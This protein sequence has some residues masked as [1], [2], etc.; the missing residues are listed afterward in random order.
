MFVESRD[1]SRQFFIQTWQKMTAKQ[2]LEPLEA[3]IAQI[4][5]EHPEY[6]AVLSAP[7]QT[8]DDE[9]LSEDG[10]SNPFLHMGLHV[11][12]QEQLQSDRPP[13]IVALYEKLLQRWNHD[14][15][16]TEHKMMECLA[17]ALWQA[18]RS[19][20]VPDERRYLECLREC[21]S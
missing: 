9:Y 11:A 19:G 15:H 7:G 18:G 17:A 1:E 13:G 10:R 12:L 14:V 4:I 2:A 21:L 16:D 6:H 5:V 3:L 20:S 8:L